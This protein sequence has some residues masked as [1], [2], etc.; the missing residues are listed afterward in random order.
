[1]STMTF[2]A[3]ANHLGLPDF[4]LIHIDPEQTARAFQAY[5]DTASK[6]T[7]VSLDD[8]SL[9]IAKPIANVD[10]TNLA[11]LLR[12]GMKLFDAMVWLHAGKPS[13]H[14]L[15]V[16]PAY[17]VDSV[18]SMH[19]VARA[20][21]YNF[22]MLL[23]Q[24]RYA[25]TRTLT[26]KPKVPNF[27]STLMGMSAEACTYAE[28]V[29]SFDIQKF[30]PKWIRYVR[31]DGMGQETL[32]RFGLGVAGYRMFGPFGLYE[33]KADLP[34]NLMRACNFARTVARAPA[35]WD[36]HP[37][38]RNP[39]VLK[40]RGNLNKNLGNLVLDCFTDE[41]IAEMVASK[42]LYRK[43][44]REPTHR[45]YLTWS[46]TDDISGTNKIFA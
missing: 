28:A 3:D 11:E 41:Q 1:M 21:F 44:E 16:D 40:N 35:T 25:P 22:F 18:P 42:L 39:N 8:I 24:A 38:T 23:T 37:I 32:S 4:N 34:A 10:A 19:T 26:D 15:V 17:A 43:P 31:F 9:R 7:G 27:L 46:E 13:T 33:P 14:P 5:L 30:D 6:L 12:H 45:N 20:V 2:R 36:V 29:C